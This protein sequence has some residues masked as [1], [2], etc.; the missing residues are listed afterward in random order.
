MLEYCNL[1]LFSFMSVTIIFIYFISYEAYFHYPVI[2]SVY[3]VV[4]FWLK[5]IYFRLEQYEKM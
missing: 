5:L 4:W 2:V 3:N 1:V